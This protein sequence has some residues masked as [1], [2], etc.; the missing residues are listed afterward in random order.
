MEMNNFLFKMDEFNVTF[1]ILPNRES[2]LHNFN[3][4]IYIRHKKFL[5]HIINL[6][7]PKHVLCFNV[8]DVS[9]PKQFSTSKSIF[10]RN[11]LW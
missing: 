4:D 9:D 2:V 11:F 8:A 6:R 7:I 10:S 1:Y 5:N 3:F